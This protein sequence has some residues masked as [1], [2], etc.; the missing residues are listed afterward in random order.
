MIQDA[1]R[2]GCTWT[3][4]SRQARGLATAPRKTLRELPAHRK[5]GPKESAKVVLRLNS[6]LGPKDLEVGSQAI[7]VQEE[8]SAKTELT[9]S[10]QGEEK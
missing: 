9:S 1:G 10:E 8:V 3:H 7:L 2:T 4:R 6:K 5:L